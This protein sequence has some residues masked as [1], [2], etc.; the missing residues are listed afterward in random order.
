MPLSNASLRADATTVSGVSVYSSVPI[1]SATQ[2]APTS[3]MTSMTYLHQGYRQFRAHALECF[4]LH[5]TCDVSTRR[6]HPQ[7]CSGW[8]NGMVGRPLR[9]RDS[10][11]ATPSY[12][13]VWH[14]G[15]ATY[16]SIGSQRG[17]TRHGRAQ[18]R[19]QR[20]G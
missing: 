10:G 1:T 13:C 15:I 18:R 8:R 14:L 2:H 4:K 16:C 19:F 12:M 5:A 17:A 6:G 20:G 7:F 9:M 3:A 11:P